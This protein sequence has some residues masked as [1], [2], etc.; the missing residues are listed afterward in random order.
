MDPGSEHN[1]CSGTGGKQ[2]ASVPPEAW[3]VI[4]LLAL[5]R[6]PLPFPAVCSVAGWIPVNYISHD[7]LTMVFQLGSANRSCW[8]ETGGREEGTSQGISP[9][10]LLWRAS[11]AAGVLG[12]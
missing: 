5:S 1:G 7:P 2:T 4:H 8:W 6:V 12:L 3:L 10:S 11:L 9:P